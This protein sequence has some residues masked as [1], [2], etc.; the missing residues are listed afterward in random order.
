MQ[1]KIGVLIW[2]CQLEGRV[3]ISTLGHPVY[4]IL[5]MTSFSKGKN[6]ITYVL[7]RH[8]ACH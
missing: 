3:G 8:L 1:Q 5:K 7:L 4:L 6:P 2:K